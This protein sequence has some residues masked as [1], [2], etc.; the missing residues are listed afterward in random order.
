MVCSV[1]R[2]L[3]FETPVYEIAKLLPYAV[4]IG[5]LNIM[6]SLMKNKKVDPSFDNQLALYYAVKV[7]YT[8]MP[9][10]IKTRTKMVNMLLRDKRVDP[11]AKNGIILKLIAM[12]TQD[13]GI[14]KRIA[15]WKGKEKERREYGNHMFIKACAAGNCDYIKFL[16]QQKWVDPSHMNN[17]ALYNS[18]ENRMDDVVN[19]LLEHLD[20]VNVNDRNGGIIIEALRLGYYPV[21]RALLNHGARI[22]LEYG[23][24]LYKSVKGGVKEVIR[25]LLRDSQLNQRKIGR[26]LF[27][28]VIEKGNTSILKILLKD[29][30]FDPGMNDN[31]AI[32]TAAD[33]LNHD[34]LKLLMKDK[35]VDPCVFNHIIMIRV[36]K[37]IFNDDVEECAKVILKDG[38]VDPSAEE[39]EVL[40]LACKYGSEEIVELLLKDSRVDP[41][42]RES[43]ALM[44]A[45]RS[46]QWKIIFK[47]LRD[48]RVDPMA[49]NGEF[50]VELCWW[51]SMYDAPVEC[52]VEEMLNYAHVNFGVRNN[53]ALCVAAKKGM[54]RTIRA[55][56]KDKK[57]QP[58]RNENKALRL[59]CKFGRLECVRA[60][61]EDKRINLTIRSEE[62]LLLAC[63]SA[64]LSIVDY[65]LKD[66]RIDPSSSGN[67]VIV[68]LLGTGEAKG[69][70]EKIIERL[71]TDERVRGK[72]QTPLRSKLLKLS[73]DPHYIIPGSLSSCCSDD[74][75]SSEW[76]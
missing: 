62:I 43:L 45:L 68:S 13:V 2:Y 39:N 70:Y 18:V 52:I 11:F 42:A 51:L 67:F 5:D 30:R 61:M 20:K 38:R 27:I 53:K 49:R 73:D 36:V 63:M 16:L 74:E 54:K 55:I 58:S 72:I 4:R 46:R 23:S 24:T 48:G 40:M 21:I 56:L 9:D 59:A 64:D 35:R 47:L 34:A 65:I 31:E 15:Q 37:K 26:N 22:P 69:K 3:S 71:I 32:I 66:K 44:Y 6:E 8:Y 76:D 25:T 33:L 60:L 29:G 28:P 17:E 10:C 50:L 14:I 41:A 12:N 57:V 75:W 7:N 19:L 1:F